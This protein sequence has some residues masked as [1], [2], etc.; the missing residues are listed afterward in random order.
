MKGTAP[1]GDGRVTLHLNE[2]DIRQALELLSRQ[3]K[4]NLLVSPNVSGTITVNFEG[5]TR[6]QA[7]EAI[8]NLGNLKA[9]EENGLIYIYTAE[10]FDQLSTRGK[11]PITRIYHLNYVRSNEV[12]V[13]VEPFL[14]PEGKI[15]STPASQ[16]GINESA[17]FQSGLSGG[18]GGGGGSSGGGGGGGGGS[19][20]GGGGGGGASGGDS[21]GGN[22][23]SGMDSLVIQDYEE[24]L[25]VIDGI[26]TRLDVQPIQVL[27]EAVIIRVTLDRTQELGVNYGV[28][29]G[30][31]QGIGIVGN[32][33]ELAS[34][35][36]F[37]PA[38][39]LSAGK[40]AAGT[41]LSANSGGVK[42]GFITGNT[43]AFIRA[44]ETIGKSNV[45]ASPR[46]LVLNKQRAELQ[47]GDRLGYR[48]LTQNQT[49]TIQQIQFLNT[50]TLLRL[51]PF[52][53]S[54]GMVR[55]EIHPER[56]TGA[57]VDGVPQLNTA[58][59]T[60]NVMVP[61][62]STL[63]V[64]GLIENQDAT[65]QSG[66]PVLGRLPVV[67]AAFRNRQQ[68]VSKR[69]L[70][71]LLTTHIWNPN[72]P[73][74]TNCIPT[75]ARAL[76]LGRDVSQRI[77]L[78]VDRPPRDGIFGGRLHYDT[79]RRAEKIQATEAA[80]GRDHVVERGENFWTISRQ[81]YGTGKYYLALWSANR[82]V[83]DAPERLAV[84]MRLQIPPAAELDPG[85]IDQ[86][87]RSMTAGRSKADALDSGVAQSG[88][89]PQSGAR[90]VTR[91]GSAPGS[92]AP[93]RRTAPR[94][95]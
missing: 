88:Y 17:D 72:D 57:I 1:S 8:F 38:Q 29:D 50:G 28:L 79:P 37:V 60:T 91:D 82:E 84:G 12:Q 49:S 59:V 21:T 42:F 92:M 81:H 31:Q 77:E 68:S 52:I 80:Q 56:S 30:L 62:G 66:V 47:L 46:L 20:G 22:S 83:V 54:D 75:P 13:M 70:I 63:V 7:L 35:A 34:A 25:Q 65:N 19:S 16:E 95:D 23:L 27:I 86:G 26:I 18:G 44:I 43:A 67:G 9:K 94:R 58:R 24:N 10:E 85:M 14:S 64:G 93:A 4:L 89:E 73:E 41:P 39:F 33:A 15:T 53:T 78:G 3:E 87:G 5:L 40:L 71:V 45:L 48:T 76:Q 69:E 36:G 61:N 2:V 74:G 51:R 6:D 90:K 11:K 32:G 55:L